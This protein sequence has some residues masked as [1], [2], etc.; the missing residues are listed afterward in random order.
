MSAVGSFNVGR[1]ISL[2]IIDPVL[3]PLRF[4]IRTDFTADPEYADLKSVAMDG[5][6]RYEYLPIGH[7][8]SMSLDRKDSTADAYFAGREAQYFN[9]QTLSK[10]TITESIKNTDGTLSIFQYSGVALKLTGRGKWAGDSK[11]E[12]KIEGMASRWRQV[13]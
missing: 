7:K 11:V 4:K 13:Q 12:Q 8:L 5:V 10:V 1:D 2:D 9:G 3:G 6:N